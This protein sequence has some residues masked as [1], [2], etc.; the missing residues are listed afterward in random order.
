[1]MATLVQIP[2]LVQQKLA[3]FARMQAEFEHCFHFQQEVH[4]QKRF[5][6]FPVGRIVSY[7]HALWICERKDR[8]LSV[9]KNIRR[10]EGTRSLELLRDW[11]AGQNAP[12]VAFLL[13]KL[14]RFSFADITASIEE[15]RRKRGD[16]TLARRLEHGR[17]VLLNRGMNL[18]HALEAMF[19]LSE[20]DLLGEVRPACEQHGHTPAQIER[21][22]ADL[23]SP[24]CTYRPH[25]LLARRNMVVMN[26]LEV[27]VLAQHA[28]LPGE[29]SRRVRPSE[30]PLAP[31]ADHV[32]DGYLPLLA[33]IHNN[34]RRVRFIDRIEPDAA[35]HITPPA[36]PGP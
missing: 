6:S 16:E 11:Q 14:D 31:F 30:Q 24:L 20:Q 4:G 10:Y 25:R 7:L 13:Q 17:L 29:R 34:L 33:P 36:A 12:I 2:E 18:M 19:S 32:I 23:A 15:A 3:A 28:D 8:L 5:P 26:K 9:Y 35:W 27:D 1:M 22:L 21:Q